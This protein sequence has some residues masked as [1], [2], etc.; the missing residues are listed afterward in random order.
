MLNKYV[1]YIIY[2]YSL[3]NIYKKFKDENGREIICLI[4]VMKI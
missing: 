3:E 2:L 1:I 4:K